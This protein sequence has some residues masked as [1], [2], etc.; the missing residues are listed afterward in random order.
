MKNM[1]ICL[2]VIL[3][4]GSFNSAPD[5]KPLLD[6]NHSAWET[7][8]SYPL[9]PGYN[10]EI[11]K[12]SDG[13]PLQAI[14]YN[15]D[16]DRVFTVTEENGVPVLHISGEVYGCIFTKEEFENFHLRLKTKWG[17]KKWDP[18]L[19][20]AMDSGILYF[21][22]GECGVDYWRAWMLSQEFQVMEHSMGDYW[23]IANSQVKARASKTG[24]NGGYRF[25][26]SASPV[27]L[28]SGTGNPGYC[29]AG[30]DFENP[31]GEW[32]TLELICFGGKSIHIVNGKVV[33]V[34]TSSGYAENGTVKPLTHGRIQ[35]QSEA[36]EVY[37]KEIEIREL[38]EVPAAYAA[39]LQ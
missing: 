33:N 18:R 28:G 24:A 27:A 3:L 2:C 20:E 17:T 9:K 38:K 4:T 29:Q 15:K 23:S 39:L 34:F 14:G 32:N 31:M 22:Q 6:K 7:Y 11:P 5:W 35:L 16:P 8:L 37:Y 21:S 10:G 25:D 19:D 30:G 26:V 12:D 1:L 13:K 36:A